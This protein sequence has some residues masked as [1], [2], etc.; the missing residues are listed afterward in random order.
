MSA[1]TTLPQKYQWGGYLDASDEE[2]RNTPSTE[3]RALFAVVHVLLRNG[4]PDFLAMQDENGGKPCGYLIDHRHAA[5]AE[6]VARINHNHHPVK[7]CRACR[8]QARV[9]HVRW[10]ESR[11]QFH[12]VH[13][14]V[15]E[16][17]ECFGYKS[18]DDHGEHLIA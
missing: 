18:L 4:Q 5:C 8:A 11:G 3:R 12:G 6:C 2:G 9:D 1:A 7:G 17:A 13:Y 10:A 14:R 15:I 16:L